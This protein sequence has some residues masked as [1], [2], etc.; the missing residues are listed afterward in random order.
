MSINFQKAAP[1]AL[2]AMG[3]LDKYVS[4]AS[5]SESLKELIKIRASQLNCCAYCIDLHTRIALSQ[6]ETAQRI[7]LLNAWRESDL[8]TTEERVVLQMTEEITN[9]GSGLSPST[10]TLATTYF[11]ETALAQI[12]MTIVLIN[13]WN[14]ISIASGTPSKFSAKRIASKP[15]AIRDGRR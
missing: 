3:E 6:G 9:I 7:F 5:L 2:K 14:R 4:E 15:E 1:G 12:V 11:D 10:Y 13:A 8:F